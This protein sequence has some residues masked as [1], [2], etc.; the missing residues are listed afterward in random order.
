[1]SEEITKY[2]VEAEFD[3]AKATKK[4]D[5]FNKKLTSYSKA[6]NNFRK[7]KMGMQRVL[8]NTRKHKMLT[9]VVKTPQVAKLKP[10]TSPVNRLET[11]SGKEKVLPNLYKYSE[12]SLKRQSEYLD[13]IKDKKVKLSYVNNLN[14]QERKV[15]LDNKIPS[16]QKVAVSVKTKT[17][18]KRL[19]SKT[20]KVKP[21]P[22]LDR[23]IRILSKVKDSRVNK[24]DQPKPSRLQTLKSKEKLYPNLYKYSEDSLKR[25]S[26]YLAKLKDKKVKLDFIDNLDK[27]KKRLKSLNRQKTREVPD[28]I[29]KVVGSD[30]K[31]L[32]KINTIKEKVVKVGKSPKQPMLNAHHKERERYLNKEYKNKV[33][34]ERSL[35]SAHILA[36]KEN[37]KFD[38]KAAEAKRSEAS[39]PDGMDTHLK[40][41]EKYLDKQYKKQLSRTKELKAAHVAAIKQNIKFDRQRKMAAAKVKQPT[42]MKPA[43]AHV[44]AREASIVQAN[45][46]ET[47]RKS[48]L[49]VAKTSFDRSDLNLTQY[50]DARKLAAQAA[51]RESIAQAKT[52]DEVRMI[53]ATERQRLRVMKQ[54]ERSMGK[55]NYLMQRMN[56][57]SKQFT[58]NMF[59]AFAIAGAGAGITRIGQDFEAVNNTMLAVSTNTQEAGS[60]F[61]FVRDEAYRLGLGLANSGKNFAKMLS[62][63]GNMSLEDTKKAFT[64]ISEMSTLLG[65][66]AEE[67]TRA[68]VCGSF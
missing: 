34:R 24:K 28:K 56:A 19:E 20:S 35:K 17:P 36:I 10:P 43:D 66:S 53:V 3:S 38:R 15:K 7:N 1:M 2:V 46:K 8:D 4:L 21:V 22:T 61:K 54:N 65:L 26:E 31:P 59:S 55:Q 16:R 58:S 37:I 52:A 11:L 33:N 40:Q 6:Q 68:K 9:D 47:R 51:L 30:K 44:K 57:S 14:K 62:A 45:R 41:R 42:I 23:K 32:Q 50:T 12:A 13:K 29:S 5:E 63:R 49:G 67:S 39:K 25:Q 64:G 18:T 27:V 60:N 48:N